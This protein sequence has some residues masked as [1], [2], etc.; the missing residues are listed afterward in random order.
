MPEQEFRTF[1][2]HP[3]IE[4]LLDCGAFTAL[5]AGEEIDLEDYMAFLDKWK[6]KL[7]GYLALDVLGNPEATDANLNIMLKR[8]FKPVPV[9][10]RGDDQARMDY[11]FTLSDFVACGGLRRPHRAQADLPYVRQKMLW[12]RGRD[13]HWL[14]FTTPR[15]VKAFTPYSCDASSW[16]MGGRFGT[17]SIYLGDWKWVNRG[18]IEKAL[19]TPFSAEEMAVVAECGFSMADVRKPINWRLDNSI[20]QTREKH[21]P[22]MVTALSWVKFIRDVRKMTGTR[23]FLACSMIGGEQYPLLKMIEATK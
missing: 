16:T 21:V 19:A 9:H 10:V 22:F 3:D 2:E 23:V 7:F 8:G 1:V 20:G 12:A 13:V 17:M 11:L 4:V 14:G 15:V 5:N 18:N 6:D